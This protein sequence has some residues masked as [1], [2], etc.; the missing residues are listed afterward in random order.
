MTRDIVLTAC[1]FADESGFGAGRKQNGWDDA[2]AG[3]PRE[4][5]WRAISRDRFDRFGRMDAM[6]KYAV[7][8]VELLGLP[9]A[10]EKSGW[11]AIAISLGTEL[12][13]LGVDVEFL[14][15]MGGPRGASPRLF[16]Y[17]LPSTAIGEIAI[18]HRISGANTC[19]AGGRD[20]GLLALMEGVGM[21][22]IGEV[23]ACVCIGCEAI[24]RAAADVVSKLSLGEEAL[25]C[26][27][28]AFF[29]EARDRAK[30]HLR[31]PLADVCIE[32][33]VAVD[34]EPSPSHVTLRELH[35]FV[36]SPEPPLED[37]L[38]L[39]APRSLGYS[40]ELVITRRMPVESVCNKET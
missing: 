15:S 3:V 16:A 13:S 35:R 14:Q 37:V 20:S 23:D 1:G 22:E 18:R 5:P 7:A 6:S 28:Y 11:P 39:P 10:P 27:A 26:S 9:P 12:G 25:H 30:E 34:S 8:V 17:T 2:S 40:D 31:A 4:F 36:A 33:V 29:I 21:I 19:L 38:H 24:S 32:K